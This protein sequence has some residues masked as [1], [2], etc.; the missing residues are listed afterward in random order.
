MFY[1]ERTIRSVQEF[2]QPLERKLP[3]LIAALLFA[4]V[5]TFGWMVNRELHTAFETAAGDRLSAA[6]ERIAGMLAEQAVGLRA[7]LRGI[8]ADSAVVAALERPGPATR[9]AVAVRLAQQ[10]VT[11]NLLASRTLYTRDCS[12]VASTGPAPDH[13]QTRR[14]PRDAFANA[15]ARDWIQPIFAVADTTFYSMIAPV[16]RAP[17]DTIGWVRHVRRLGDSRSAQALTA[18]VG[19]ESSLLLGNAA[20]PDLWTDLLRV[21]PGPPRSIAQG[22]VTRFSPGGGAPALGVVRS[23]PGTPW[24]VDVQMPEETA[25]DGQY[26]ALQRLAVVAAL[27]VL[28]GALGAWVLGNHVTRPLVELTRAAEGLARG[29]YARRVTSDRKD[30]LGQLVST[31]NRMADHVQSANMELSAQ[32][33]ELEHRYHEA[34]D[35]AHEL[36]MSNQ[37]LSDAAGEAERA[38]RD[39]AL[40]ES[41][42]EEVLAQA[43]FG[44]AVLDS[45]LRYVRVNAALATMNGVPADEHAGK[46]PADVVPEFGAVAESHLRRV[47]ATGETLADERPSSAAADGSRQYWLANY[48]PVRDT[49]GAVTG[50]GIIVLDTTSHHDL[51]A[52]LLQAQKMEAVGRLA[53][54]VAHDFNNLLTVISS[55]SEMALQTLPPEDPLYADMKE[56]RSSADRASRLTR[57]L[58]AFSRKQVMQPQTLDLNR[59]AT[60]MERMLRRL[61]GEDVKLV[62]DLN[63]NIGEVRADPGQIEQVLMNL[64][65]NAR[66]AMPDGGRLVIGTSN[67]TVRE[68][69]TLEAQRVPPGEYVALC[70]SDTGTGMSDGTMAHLFEPFFTTKETGQGTGLGLSTV[71]GIIK[72]SGGEIL[73]RSQEGAGSTFTVYLPRLVRGTGGPASPEACLAEAGGGTET[74]LLVEDDAALRNLA[75]RILTDAGY[76]VVEAR[77]STTAI[78][79]GTSY[80]GAIDLVL[81]DVVMPQVDGRAVGERLTALRPGIR[82]LFM[83]GY[84]DDMVMKRGIRSQQTDFL[85]KPFTPEQLVRRIREV[86]DARVSAPRL[87]AALGTSPTR[88]A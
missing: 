45:S 34:Q 63:R 1:P 33:A 55:Y 24:V 10:R 56:I 80:P 76:K 21:R 86:L 72:Q 43:P 58:L 6:A 25:H 2:L 19:R 67:E 22:T 87:Q 29:D 57:Q 40:A 69:I 8:V 23:V 7:E 36:E 64:V 62:L 44:I 14:C 5:M 16:V 82:V 73:V 84:T 53:G 28:V 18:F 4:V 54:G 50:A 13:P 52:Q 78:E 9:E 20:G 79:L 51:E 49:N 30:E 47:L 59:V 60:E 39:R 42:L 85:Q 37:E 83:S 32:A 65:L 27:C 46:R 74:I 41:L 11:S 71:Y 70:V 88:S 17:G 77:T 75:R 15:A 3:L 66:D 48:F 38:H 81:T 26:Q 68:E 31:F 61:I 35:L 12:V